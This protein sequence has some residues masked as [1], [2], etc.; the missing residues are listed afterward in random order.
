M[1]AGASAGV[2]ESQSLDPASKEPARI[3]FDWARCQFDV[4]MPPSVRDL[5]VTDVLWTEAL[6][7]INGDLLG[8]YS[9]KW[10]DPSLAESTALGLLKTAVR[11]G[12]SQSTG[13]ALP[14]PARIAL[15]ATE[16]AMGAAYKK[17][18]RE[19]WD[20]AVAPA[21]EDAV[22]FFNAEAASAGQKL[23]VELV[24]ATLTPLEAAEL[25][26]RRARVD[27]AL[28]CDDTNDEMAEDAAAGKAARARLRELMGT[29]YA[30]VDTKGKTAEDMIHD[31]Q[32]KERDVPAVLAGLVAQQVPTLAFRTVAAKQ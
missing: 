1:G 27:L 9:K 20:G 8:D 2:A 19:E 11:F 18:R 6:L 26:T 7:S 29:F 25:E 4:W 24:D 3:M 5:G 15:R 21:L 17:K 31:I 12:V 32:P 28:A 16:K 14:P 30:K 23:R 22:H 13:V 10:R